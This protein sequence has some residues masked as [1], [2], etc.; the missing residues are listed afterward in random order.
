MASNQG[1]GDWVEVGGSEFHYFTFEH[2]PG[3]DSPVASEGEA[4]E[5]TDCRSL[6]LIAKP[7]EPICPLF[8]PPK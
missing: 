6:G 2:P 3:G 8:D 5:Q 1:K 4:K 7:S